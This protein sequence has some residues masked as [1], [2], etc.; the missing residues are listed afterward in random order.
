MKNKSTILTLM[1]CLLMACNAPA[2]HVS[3]LP[4]DF[5]IN[6]YINTFNED[7]VFPNGS[8]G[9]SYWFFAPGVT[10][11]LSIKTSRIFLGNASHAPHSHPADEAFY[12][13]R[14]PVIVHINGEERTIE[15]GTFYYCPSHS[16]H[17]IARVNDTDTIQYFIMTRETH[18]KNRAY[19]VGKEDY[20]ID[21][22]IYYPNNDLFWQDKSQA[23]SLLTLSEQFSGGMRV[24]MHRFLPNVQPATIATPY[25][26]EQEVFYVV[27]G[28]ADVTLEGQ[29]AHLQPN[30]AF[31]C[32]EGSLRSVAQ[33]GDEPLVLI[34][35]TTDLY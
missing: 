5:S 33:T 2:K 21:D 16:S 29:K 9:W 35:C 7:S 30:T 19:P 34:Q 3:V 28:E 10:D 8:A 6:T 31:W 23:A 27:S 12:I 15:T 1:V 17:N 20:T 18:G 26:A 25:T 14:G 4:A 13:M 11:T 22:C 24:Q 32:P